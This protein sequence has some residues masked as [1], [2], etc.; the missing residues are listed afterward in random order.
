MIRYAYN[1]QVEPPGPFVHV[2]FRC[3][4]TGQTINNLP[5]QIDTA[6][7]RTVIPGDLVERLGLVPLDELPVAGFGGQVFLISTYYVELTIRGLAPQLV[8]VLAHAE[9]PYV[10]L[11]R[12]ILNGCRLWLD[13]PELA[14]EIG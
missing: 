1:R 2:S 12:D 10:L 13:G 7:D 6:A 11:G 3:P 4:D 5:A 14:L 8:E 9:E